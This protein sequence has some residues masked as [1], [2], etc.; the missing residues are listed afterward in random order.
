MNIDDYKKINA[1]GVK[2]IEIDGQKHYM[3]ISGVLDGDLLALIQ[4]EEL[5]Q[6]DKM[7]KFLCSI[8]CDE[9]G[10]R[11]FDASNKDHYDIVKTLPLEVQTP[12]IL[13]AQE[14]FFPKKKESKEAK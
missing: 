12:L 13:E 11:I 6:S 2:S 5:E 9:S 3:R 1:D 8:I 14:I 4:D 10:K 7:I